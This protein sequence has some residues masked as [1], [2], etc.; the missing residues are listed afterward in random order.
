MVSDNQRQ[1]TS[2]IRVFLSTLISPLEYLV[3][4]PSNIIDWADTSMTSRSQLI[5]DIKELQSEQ[6][7][8]KVQAQTMVSLEVE[9]AHLRQLLGS[10]KKERGRRRVAEIMNVS[11]DPS[12]HIVTINK[13]SKDDVFVGQPVLDATGILGQVISTS[14]LTSKVLL[15]TDASHAL[16][17]KILRNGIRAIAKGSGDPNQLVL[18]Q[19]PH[20][21]DIIKG[22]ILVTSGLGMRFPSGFP[23]AVIETVNNDPGLAFANA[24][25]TTSADLLRTGLVILLWPDSGLDKK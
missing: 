16:P 12:K 22:D 10:L 4:I 1:Q 2:A 8:L 21:V 6:M 5:R 23:V 17:V 3:T 18:T 25:A 20:T 13:G 24:S 15:I 14:I 11:S 9:N 19:I 7:I